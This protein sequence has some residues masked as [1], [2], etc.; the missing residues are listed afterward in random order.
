MDALEPKV[1][2]ELISGAVLDLLD[3]DLFNKRVAEEKESKNI[4][5]KIAD[6]Y[7]D[8]SRYIDINF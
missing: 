4:L 1:I 3:M 6:N 5:T 2:D 7:E 8:V